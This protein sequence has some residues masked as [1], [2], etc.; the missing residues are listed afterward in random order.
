MKEGG[1]EVGEEEKGRG[2]TERRADKEA[3]KR[4]I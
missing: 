3:E 2:K 4:K 1:G